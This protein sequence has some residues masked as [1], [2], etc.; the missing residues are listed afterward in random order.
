[1]PCSKYIYL[2]KYVKKKKK[3]EIYPV[4]QTDIVI[5]FLFWLSTFFKIMNANLPLFFPYIKKYIYSPC[6]FQLVYENPYIKPTPNIHFIKQI[7]N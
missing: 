1:M 3:I 5:Y 4:Y 6:T 2:C 7:Y